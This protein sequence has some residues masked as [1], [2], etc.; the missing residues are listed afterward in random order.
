MLVLAP[1][2]FTGWGYAVQAAMPAIL[3]YYFSHEWLDAEDTEERGIV[4]LVGIMG[5]L[6]V[7]AITWPDTFLPVLG[8][9]LFVGGRVLA[10]R[11]RPL[12]R[13]GTRWWGGR[14]RHGD[15]R[16][17]GCKSPSE[18]I[19]GPNLNTRPVFG[20][21]SFVPL[22]RGGSMEPAGLKENGIWPFL[23]NSWP[24]GPDTA[25]N[26]RSGDKQS[27][28]NYHAELAYCLARYILGL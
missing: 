12:A 8:L 6:C 19:R 13:H 18:G 23:S 27:V 3:A 15:L 17:A 25:T 9:A 28:G 4:A 21:P 16:M 11:P 5:V 20:L 2:P 26:R 10:S 14:Y 1:V 22:V 24:K 7:L